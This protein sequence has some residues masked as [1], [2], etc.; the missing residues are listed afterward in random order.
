[1]IS[2]RGEYSVSQSLGDKRV[3]I[4]SGP[5]TWLAG[6]ASACLHFARPHVRESLIASRSRLPHRF[7]KRV[8]PRV[9]VAL[10]GGEPARTFLEWA[11]DHAA[12][13]LA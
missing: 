9:H 2:P 12:E 8:R 3:T 5:L 10:R 6:H 7:S 1:M 13:F 4:G 11:T